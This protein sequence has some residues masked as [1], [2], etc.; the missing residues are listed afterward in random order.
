MFIRSIFLTILFI[1]SLFVNL[2]IA[3]EYKE[4]ISNEIENSEKTSA[5]INCHSIYT[6]GIVKDWLSSRHARINVKKAL[7]K[8][9][10]DRRISVKEINEDLSDTT[11]GCFECHSLNTEKHKDNFNHFG[12]KINVVVSSSDCKTCHPLEVGEYSNS[13]KYFAYKNLMEN[14]VYLT[15]VNT[16]NGLKK[17]EGERLISLLP[18]DT[19]LHETC[20]GCHGTMVEVKGKKQI[21]TEIGVIEVPDLTNWPNQGVGR[22]NPDGSFG[23]CSACH[24][25]HSFSIV[26]ARKPFTCSQCHLE[27]DVPAWNVYDESKHGNILLSKYYEWDF[28]NVPWVLGEDIK[29][30]S[31]ATCHNSLLVSPDKKIIAERTHNFG[32]RLWVRL[33]GLIYSHAQPISG[34]TTIIKNSDGLPLPASFKNEPASQYLIDIKTQENRKALMSNICSSCHSSSWTEKHF[35]KL[36]STIKE[37]DEMTLTATNILLKAWDKGI[38]DKTN[39]FDE[40]IEQM[41]IKQWLFYSNSIR[42]ASA[43]S[44]APDYTAFKNGW[45]YLTENIKHMK[46]WLELKEKLTEKKQ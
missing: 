45:W 1:F 18:S 24:P 15:L 2:L 4:E 20:L 19:T 27:P 29:A 12:Y 21:K 16:I 7:K 6:P 28:D 26:I 9:E 32:S 13:K 8:P 38:E 25:R 35:T 31:C 40:S 3:S 14:P 34:D 33:F 30:P 37:T 22:A 17:I 36:N 41:W 39:P 11:I 42:Y 10:L 23:A 46:E 44:G 5:C 43:M